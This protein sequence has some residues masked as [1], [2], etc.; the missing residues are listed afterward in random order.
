M[1]GALF[2][3]ALSAAE[4]A[5]ALVTTTRGEVSVV[6]EGVASA[7]PAPPFVLAE[8]E[9]LR[10]GDG[11]LAVLLAGGLATQVLGPREL[12][13]SDL[14]PAPSGSGGG[15]SLDALLGRRTSVASAG[16]SRGASDVRMIRPIP[17]SQVLSVPYV[18][19]D[20][21]GCGPVEVKLYDFGADRDVWRGRGG[22]RIPYTGPALGEGAYL[23]GVGPREHAISVVSASERQEIEALVAAA[24][25]ATDRWVGAEADPAARA[26]VEAAVYL[27]A[28]FPS[29]AL[30]TIDA[31]LAAH[32]GD[33]ALLELLRGY[34]L[35]AGL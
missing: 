4:A 17:G 16:A 23:V 8:G 27:Q 22:A 20:C 31:A 30:Y 19:V 7:A 2:V 29:E 32:P 3:V 1:V 14:T 26:S 10:V 13:T 21:D 28:G 12:A 24:R 11:G 5:P 33:A 25:S 34:E 6:R 15:G 9:R 18:A 35:R